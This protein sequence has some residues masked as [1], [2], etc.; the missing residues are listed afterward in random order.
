MKSF[1]PIVLGIVCVVL[2]VAFYLTKQ[3]DNTQHDADVSSFNDVSN[4][5]GTAHLQ[6][7]DD[8]GSILTLSNSLDASQSAWLTLSNQLVGDQSTL[9]LNAEQISNLNAKVTETEAA[10]QTLEQHA[11]ELTNQ[12]AGLAQQLAATNASLGEAN[13]D[14]A[15]AHHDY[16]LLERRFRM[17]VAERIVRERKFYNISELQDQIERLKEIPGSEVTADRIYAGLDVEVR[18]NGT[19]HVIAPY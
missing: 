6:I 17:N 4:Q 14:L 5:L 10:N 9:A 1:L 13:Q 12:A 16:E 11:M 15:Q 18:S 7:A 2:A 8:R 19:F 3:S